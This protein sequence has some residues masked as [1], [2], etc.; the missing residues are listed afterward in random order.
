MPVKV[1][2]LRRACHR[3]NLSTT[4]YSLT[5]VEVPNTRINTL[6]RQPAKFATHTWAYP[7]CPSAVIFGG[8]LVQAE[9]AIADTRHT[10]A[11][12]RP[13]NGPWRLILFSDCP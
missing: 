11:A 12:N 1:N 9:I 3:L 8:E 7:A 10:A 2:I 6:I 4:E 5:N 13:G